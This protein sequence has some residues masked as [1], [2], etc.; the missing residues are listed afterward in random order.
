MGVHCRGAESGG[1][2]ASERV[3][4]CEK[5]ADGTEAREYRAGKAAV[6]VRAPMCRRR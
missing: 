6:P 1:G 4:K 2:R 3:P 5:T